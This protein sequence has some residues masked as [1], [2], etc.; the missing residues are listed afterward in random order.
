[1]QLPPDVV[2][3]LHQGAFCLLS[4]STGSVQSVLRERN[5]S[6]GDIRKVFCAEHEALRRRLLWKYP[7][8]TFV[9]ILLKAGAHSEPVPLIVPLGRAARWTVHQDGRRSSADPSRSPVGNFACRIVFSTGANALGCPVS[10]QS[11]P[12]VCVLRPKCTSVVEKTVDYFRKRQYT[13][14]NN[15]AKDKRPLR[16][17]RTALRN[18]PDMGLWRSSEMSAEGARRAGAETLRQKDRAG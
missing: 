9:R 14:K 15:T 18:R 4:S 3:I 11:Q 13:V 8:L 16:P 1:M 5:E 10:G 2:I 17:T 7:L 6:F 12:S